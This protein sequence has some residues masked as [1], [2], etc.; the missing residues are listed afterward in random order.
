[1]RPEPTTGASGLSHIRSARDQAGLK[2]E[3]DDQ[4]Q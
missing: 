1:M 4:G 3:Y 2:P